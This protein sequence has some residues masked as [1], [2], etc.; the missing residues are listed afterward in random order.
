MSD[1]P[2]V[3]QGQTRMSDLPMVEQSDLPTVEQT[4]LSVQI[5]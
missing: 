3:V 4:F 5:Y 2:T 1:L